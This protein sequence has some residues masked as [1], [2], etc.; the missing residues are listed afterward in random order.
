MTVAVRKGELIQSLVAKQKKLL[1][2]VPEGWLSCQSDPTDSFSLGAAIGKRARMTWTIL[3]N[4]S[5]T[6]WLSP[7]VG[8]GDAEG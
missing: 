5:G 8:G 1:G 6:A 4:H 7:V 3:P 2:Q